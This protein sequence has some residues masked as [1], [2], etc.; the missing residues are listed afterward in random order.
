M[1]KKQLI[2]LQKN[3]ILLQNMYET[4]DPKETIQNVIYLINEMTA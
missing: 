4:E 1:D 3:L 2:E